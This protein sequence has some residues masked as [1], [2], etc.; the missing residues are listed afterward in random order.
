MTTGGRYHIPKEKRYTKG[1]ILHIVSKRDKGKTV[2]V[3]SAYGGG[4]VEL[5]A[6]AI[7]GRVKFV[8]V[9]ATSDYKFRVK[10]SKK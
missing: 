2:V 3:E 6:N 5:S 10:E 7:R 8:N 9:E 1:D 4:R